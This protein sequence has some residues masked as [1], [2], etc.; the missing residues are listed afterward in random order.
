MKLK[1]R[2]LAQ[3]ERERSATRG[4]IIVVDNATQ[5][6][7]AINRA[8]LYRFRIRDG[9]LLLQTL[10]WSAGVVVFNLSLKH[11]TEMPFA[12]NQNII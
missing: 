12:E 3:L 6:L 2:R 1:R 9:C 5:D 10:M 8:R 7:S 4:S 11:A